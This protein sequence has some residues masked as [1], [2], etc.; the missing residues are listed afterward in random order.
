MVPS[1]RIRVRVTV[2][3]KEESGLGLRSELR[4]QIVST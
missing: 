2:T 4:F 1:I 3:V